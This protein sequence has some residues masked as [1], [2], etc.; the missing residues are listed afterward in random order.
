MHIKF[1]GANQQI[2][3]SCYFLEVGGLKLLIDCGLYQERMYTARNWEQSPVSPDEIDFLLLTHIHLD[4]S[5]LL[6]KIVREGLSNQILT[7]SPSKELIPIMLLDSAHIQEEDAEFKKKRHAKEGRKGPFPEI[8]LYT[9]EE[10][11]QVFPLVKS[12]PY[13]SSFSLA[14]N[15][16][17]IFHDAGHILGS[18]MIELMISENG[19]QNRIIFSGDIGQWNRPIIRNP[20]VF[21]Q[22]DYVIM[23]STYGNR[24]HEDPADVEKLLC[25]VVNETVDAGGNIVI[26][27]FAVERAQ[28]LMFYLSRLARQNKIPDLMIFLDSPMAVNITQVFK[29]HKDS[30]DEETRAIF[31]EGDS[32]FRF[33][34]L[35]LVRS[36]EESKAINFIN[37][38][39]IIMAGSGMCTGGRIKHHLV[40]NI[41]RPESTIL[42]VCYQASGTLGR[43]ILDRNSQVRILGKYYPVNARIEEIHGFSSHA[44]RNGLLKWVESLRFPP[45][46][47]FVTHGEINA[48]F[49]I[50]SEIKKKGWN[51]EVPEY[52][53]EWDLE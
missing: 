45:K 21:E 6:P 7:T 33:P 5:G 9:V 48:S 53:E 1:L 41:T 14:P 18:A 38:P 46:R 17:V 8:P 10:A 52:L 25:Q 35:K 43:Q 26:P 44:D 32:P 22:A 51:V 11:R 23:E 37:E 15:V 19:K 27:T 30:M 13:G 36:V 3:G 2:T 39:C 34:G 12:V 28:E 4:H 42:F 16:S 49:S 29:N 20:S 24:I 31:N 47:L 50:A 40:R